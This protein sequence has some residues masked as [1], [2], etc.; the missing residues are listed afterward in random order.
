MVESCGEHTD[1]GLVAAV[2]A[3]AL[4]LRA[5]AGSV[6]AAAVVTST[7]LEEWTAIMLHTRQCFGKAELECDGVRTGDALDDGGGIMAIRHSRCLLVL[8]DWHSSPHF[9][10]HSLIDVFRVRT[11]GNDVGR[12]F[13]E[14]Q[15]TRFNTTRSK[16]AIPP[17]RCLNYLERWIGYG[18]SC[19]W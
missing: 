18:C 12:V 8:P 16:H 1:L 6:G 19:E 14:D 15:G 4:S 5:R 11:C 13:D 3:G 2:G 9:L 10:I 17:V 7:Y